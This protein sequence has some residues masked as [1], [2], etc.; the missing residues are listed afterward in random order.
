G[1]DPVTGDPRPPLTLEADTEEAARSLAE[2]LF[3]LKVERVDLASG[4]PGAGQDRVTG[5]PQTA[6]SNVRA[7]RPAASSSLL[8]KFLAWFGLF[9]CCLARWLDPL[10]HYVLGNRAFVRGWGGWRDWRMIGED[11]LK[12]YHVLPAYLFGVVYFVPII[13]IELT[14]ILGTYYSS[15]EWW[16]L[17][18]QSLIIVPLGSVV[19]S[20]FICRM[21]L[22]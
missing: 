1:Q 13:A 19:I 7:V 22:L 9:L 15:G 6:R 16:L 11:V 14:I 4:A 8:G 20:A 12:K 5:Q 18:L 3:G 2:V 21:G 17:L 10:G